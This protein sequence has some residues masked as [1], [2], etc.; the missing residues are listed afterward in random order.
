MK[1][2]I[3]PKWYEN[4]KVTCACGNTFTL[5]T[6]VPEI[7]IEVCSTCHPFFTGQMRY[8][9]TAGR[10]DAF[11]E[12]RAKAQKQV[13]TKVEKRKLKRLKKIQEELAK[14]G[15]LEELRTKEKSKKQ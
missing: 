4:S 9:D 15:S 6:T 13:I 10:V 7:N 3:H 1:A 8:V 5:G 2:K 14:P 11:R 12:K